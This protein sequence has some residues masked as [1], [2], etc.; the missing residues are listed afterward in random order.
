MAILTTLK[1]NF[2]LYLLIAVNMID[3]EC[4]ISNLSNLLFSVVL[5]LCF[6]GI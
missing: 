5:I 4:R 2:E 1:I 6:F 3:L